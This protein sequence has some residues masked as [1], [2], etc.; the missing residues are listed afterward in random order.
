VPFLL[1]WG[2]HHLVN[3]GDEDV[4]FGIDELAHEGNEIG[5]GLVHHA[6]K[7]ARMEIPGRASDRN[8]IIREA[9]KS[10]SQRRGARIEPVVI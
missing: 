5:H 3:A 4:T 10:V 9:T 1:V 8:L 7:D 2:R 6:A